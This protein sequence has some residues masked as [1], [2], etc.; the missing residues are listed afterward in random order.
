MLWHTTPL[1]AYPVFREHAAYGGEFPWTVP[2][3]GRHI[4]YEPQDYAE[5]TRLLD[6]SLLLGSE[7]YPLCGQD[8]G[9]MDH[10]VAAMRKV[11][12]ALDEVVADSRV[13]SSA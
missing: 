4:E 11:L 6:C 8:E 7:R 10:Y 9:V 12:G 1:P 13:P 5:A 2:P 3:A